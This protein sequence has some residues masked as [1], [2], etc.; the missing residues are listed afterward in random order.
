MAKEK[1]GKKAAPADAPAAAAA[2]AAATT[3]VDGR[4]ATPPAAATA[5]AGAPSVGRVFT[6]N[7]GCLFFFPFVYIFTGVGELAEEGQFGP[8]YTLKEGDGAL[9]G[10]AAWVAIF[11]LLLLAQFRG[12]SE[13]E[14]A[15]ASGVHV[16][17]A[18]AVK[19]QAELRVTLK[20][21]EELQAKNAELAREKDV[22]VCKQHA[23]LLSLLNSSPKNKEEETKKTAR[24]KKT[25]PKTDSSCRQGGSEVEV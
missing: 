13:V 14:A 16:Y 19:T 9:Y 22:Q 7:L 17:E 6:P 23:L 8:A 15:A 21:R 10:F 4:A 11:A 5:A 18:A 12:P 25:T 1:K 2:P 20:E 3:A 24:R